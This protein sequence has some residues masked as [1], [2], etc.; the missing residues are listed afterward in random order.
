MAISDSDRI[1]LQRNKLF[2]DIRFE[3]VEPALQGCQITALKSGA[4]LLDIGQKNASLY[5]VLDGELRVYLNGRG[6]PVHAVLGSGEC[7]G[8]LSLVDGENTAA[9]VIA[10]RDTRLLAVPHDLVWS[11]VESSN[12]IARNLLG[13][14]AGRI[15]NDNLLQVT[16]PEPSLEFEVAAN[17]D[18]LTGLHNKNWMDETFHRMAQRCE[19]N[20][21]PLF[22]LVAD[23]D[24]FKDFVGRHGHLAGDSVLKGVARIMAI[25][26]RPH[27]LLIYA[28]GDRFAVLLPERSLDMAM[29]MAERLREAVAAPALHIHTGSAPQAANTTR[30][31]QD[32]HVTVSLGISA[33]QPGDTLASLWA[34]ADEALQ[35]AKTDGRN[36]VKMAAAHS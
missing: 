7:V 9:L 6:L 30:T 13:I 24:H 18:T 34:A 17:I 16:T 10:A 28:G 31:T 35:Q 1:L 19:R 32:E 20:G 36:R 3:S 21:M 5:L 26:L 4:T 11:L 23:L 22:L 29:K 8:E 33:M 12:G 2:R 14:L 15:R 25:N 27:D